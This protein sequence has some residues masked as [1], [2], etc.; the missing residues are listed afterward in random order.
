M[1]L[2]TKELKLMANTIRQDIVKMLVE[3]KS[4]HPGGSLG[5][6]D[7]FSVLYFHTLRHDPKLPKWEDRDRFVLSNGHICPVLYATLANADYFPKSELMTLRKIGSKLQGHPHKGTLPGIENSSG[8]LGQGISQAV[9]MAIVAKKEKKSWRVYSV[10]GDG[11]LNEGQAWEAFMLAS[12]YKL[13]NLVFIVDRNNI[14]IDGTTDEVLPLE[15]LADKFRSFGFAVIET[16]GNDVSSIINALEN[17]KKISNEPIVIIAKT[18][19]GKGVSFMEGKFSWHGKAPNKEQA[20][21]AITELEN[22][23]KLLEVA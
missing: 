12:K 4:G 15:P 10:V 9:G 23:R 21:L 22:E 11:E 6:A 2:E 17:T 5:M 3:A 1:K 8:P 13:D 7:I 18:M 16:A 20:E 19:P 14:Q